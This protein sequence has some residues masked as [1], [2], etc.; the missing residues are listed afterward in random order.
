MEV[1]VCSAIFC[2]VIRIAGASLHIAA[3]ILEL[4][5]RL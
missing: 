3:I 4:S 5:R 2:G 1:R